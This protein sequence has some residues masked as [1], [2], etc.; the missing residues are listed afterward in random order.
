MTIEDFVNKAKKQDSRNIFESYSGDV[1]II[2]SD[3][4]NFFIKANPI[5]V[6]IETRKFGDIHF[7]PLEE[8]NSLNQEYSFMPEDSFIFASTNGDPI[9]I[10]NSQYY[11]TYESRFLP[12]QISNSFENFLDYIKIK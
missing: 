7:Y 2:P 4:R 9:F 12:E 10:Q 6:Q 1:S 8:I 3:I 5:N 11:I